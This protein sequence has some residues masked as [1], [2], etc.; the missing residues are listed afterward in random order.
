[1]LEKGRAQQV[2]M[3]HELGRLSRRDFLLVST[4][5]LALAGCREQSAPAPPAKKFTVESLLGTTPFYIAHRGSGDNWPEHTALAYSSAIAYGVKAIEVSVCSTSDGI[6]VCHHDLNTLRLTGHDLDISQQTY[7]ALERLRND[8]R[9]WLGPASQPQPI[10]KLKDV[11]DAHAATHV[12]FIEDKQATNTKALLDLMDGYPDAQDHFV[13]KQTSSST[14]RVE[15]MA[16]GYKT[17][18]Y[19]MDGSSDTYQKYAPNFDYLGLYHAATDAEIAALV[20]YGKPVI[21]WEVH[22]RSMRDR[23]LALGVRGFMCSNIPY[24][25]NDVALNTSDSFASGIRSPGD[26]PWVINWDLQPQLKPDAGSVELADG[27]DFSY[28]MGSLCPVPAGSYSI[29]FELRWRGP[30]PSGSGLAGIAFGLADDRPYRPKVPGTS[31][32]YHLLI[33]EKGMLELQ[34]RAADGAVTERLASTSTAT[35]EPDQWMKFSVNVTPDGV[36]CSRL[37]AGVQ[38]ITAADTAHR[39]GYFVLCKAYDG[40]QPLEFRFVTVSR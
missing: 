16:R 38:S 40:E 22:T 18:G 6:L 11:L 25:T 7:A 8:A 28:S 39:G 5:S 4:A 14:A 30:V 10:P 2:P 1:M 15:A 9:Q 34:R 24:V 3:S 36:R 26:L 31:G 27:S 17:W 29:A 19:F 20:A 12:I 23:L 21:V 37:D 35:P 33:D 32:G 13:W